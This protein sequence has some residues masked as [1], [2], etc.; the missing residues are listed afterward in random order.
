MFPSLIWLYPAPGDAGVRV[1][2]GQDGFDTAVE[3]QNKGGGGPQPRNVMES[4]WVTIGDNDWESWEYDGNLGGNIDLL[5][6]F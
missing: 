1:G 2:G 4:P 6:I 3:G 5:D